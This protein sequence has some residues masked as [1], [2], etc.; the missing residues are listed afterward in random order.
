[1]IFFQVIP[2]FRAQSFANVTQ[3]MGSSPLAGSTLGLICPSRVSQ[4]HCEQPPKG[5]AVSDARLKGLYCISSPENRMP[6]GRCFSFV[7]DFFLIILSSSE[8]EK[9]Q[10]LHH[11]PPHMAG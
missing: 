6:S 10:R 7:D 1:M 2:I 8:K 11:R 3:H 4:L 5:K 9:A